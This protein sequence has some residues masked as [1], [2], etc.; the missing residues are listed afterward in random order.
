MMID[1]AMPED[2]VEQL[3]RSEESGNQEAIWQLLF[4]H[5]ENGQEI[6]RWIGGMPP[7]RRLSESQTV[8]VDGVI[9]QLSGWAKLCRTNV[10][11]DV[12]AFDLL[13]P[14]EMVIGSG[15]AV[16][17]TVFHRPL[18]AVRTWELPAE[19]LSSFAEKNIALANNISRH[20]VQ[21]E[22]RWID[23]HRNPHG[24]GASAGL[25]SALIDLWIRLRRTGFGD[26]RSFESPLRPADLADILRINRSEAKRIVRGFQR[27]GLITWS[28][29]R[30]DLHDLE[31]LAREAAPCD[32]SAK[33]TIA[34]IA[35][36]GP[37][38][39]WMMQS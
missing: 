23:A 17:R 14:G 25:A 9:Y 39:R 33:T 36:H 35:E 24:V 2:I 7:S 6:T 16:A 37:R 3:S 38:G 27:A 20:L 29:G 5:P 28:P 31:G 1:L 18:T 15:T 19:F 21:Q 13:L 30:V 34:A 10:D 32:S 12:A 11:G 26:K 8:P 22:N 4:D